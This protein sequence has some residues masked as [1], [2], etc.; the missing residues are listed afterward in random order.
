LITSPPV[1]QSRKD[2]RAAMSKQ[3]KSPFALLGTYLR[4]QRRQLLL[5]GALLAA[6][7]VL[8]IANPQILRSFI[9]ATQS[10]AGQSLTLAALLF[11]GV[12]LMSQACTIAA[13]K[14]SQEVAWSAM[15]RLREELT[16]HC[17][18]LDLS[19]HKAHTPGELIE[20]I[21]GDIATLGNFFSQFAIMVV[22][23]LLLLAGV[24]LLLFRE[25]WWIGL[26]YS[27]LA[28]LALL[29][30]RLV[31]RIIMPH[32][33]LARAA[34]AELFSVVEERLAG[35]EDIRA[36]DFGEYTMRELSLQLRQRLR[37]ERKAKI[38]STWSVVVAFSSFAF[39]TAL[40]FIV[41]WTLVRAGAI[42]VGT[43]Y[44]LFF[45]V[46]LL[47]RPI[48]Q[49]SD[50]MQDFQKAAASIARLQELFEVRSTLHDGAR[51][52]PPGALSVVFEDVSFSYEQDEVILREL[53]LTLAPGR[54]LGLLG[55]S[56]SGKTTLTRL[57]FRLYDPQE[58][59]LRLGEVEL[60]EARIA[61]LRG[62]IGLVTQEVQLFQ[63]S[64]RD[65]LT[66]FDDS[67]PDQ[68]ILEVLREL[69]LEGWYRRLPAG[70]DTLLEAGSGGLSAGEGQLL[71]FCRVFLK[72]PGLVIL[73]EASSR[74]DP[75]TEQL[76]ERAID[77]LL[78]GRTAI[79]IAHRLSTVRRAD[80]IAILEQG[81]VLEHGPR[82]E[83]ARR[84]DSHFARLLERGMAE[85]LA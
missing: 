48:L 61:D 32:W 26:S 16:L 75:A 18:R 42:S 79:I 60:R 38:M 58:G 22:G 80:D 14:L 62:R 13:T 43:A 34:S 28:A 59:S 30:L 53:S 64:V 63:A 57:L 46:D 77:R 82:A 9:D 41:G 50:Q 6:G 49:I 74:L 25:G 10:G 69:G 54:V 17:L 27:A 29:L 31:Q 44:L 15:N 5:L 3:E 36:N 1:C 83:L 12:G 35:L 24:L 65:N 47:V 19:F 66:F 8:Q 56:G 33:K 76:I 39:S 85:V 37:L 51:P 70:L 72:D 4:P 20:R 23:N 21:D 67:V 2:T 11:I 52:L 55:R 45:Y 78:Q 7:I 73:D 81:R 84:P 71:T 40:S 68:R